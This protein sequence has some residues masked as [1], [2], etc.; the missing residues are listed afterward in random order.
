[1]RSSGVGIHGCRE[2]GFSI[3]LSIMP[4]CACVA[5]RW[6][7][8]LVFCTKTSNVAPVVSTSKAGHG[9]EV[10]GRGANHG[11]EAYGWHRQGGERVGAPGGPQTMT[12]VSGAGGGSVLAS[13]SC[14]QHTTFGLRVAQKASRSQVGRANTPQGRMGAGV[15][16]QQGEEPG[17][18]VE[19]HGCGRN[20]G[21]GRGIRAQLPPL[22]HFN[23]G[24]PGEQQSRSLNHPQATEKCDG[25]Q[26]SHHSL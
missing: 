5:S 19:W 13:R 15:G 3:T 21:D 4:A 10:R 14:A 7:G 24:A 8:M 26:H 22:R 11:K 20:L 9:N 6:S 23:Y 2:H 18:T 25:S 12:R 1:M 16:T 17:Q